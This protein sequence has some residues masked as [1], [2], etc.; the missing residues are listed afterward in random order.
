M[1]ISQSA[2]FEAVRIFF[3]LEGRRGG[4]RKVPVSVVINLLGSLAGHV[5]GAEG[6]G[7]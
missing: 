3:Q 1:E 6:L 7:T 4:V 5:G 2:L